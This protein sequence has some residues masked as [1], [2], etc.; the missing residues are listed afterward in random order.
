M[1]AACHSGRIL[2]RRVGRKTYVFQNSDLAEDTL[3]LR[4]VLALELVEN[5]VAV[6]AAFVWCCRPVAA[7]L[8]CQA[9]AV[10]VTARVAVASSWCAIAARTPIYIASVGVWVG[11]GARV[12]LEEG[13]A[14]VAL[15]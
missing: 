11:T 9:V 12:T 10:A 13:T 14:R 1:L 5:G 15:V 3:N 4:V 8:W 7:V 6:L 2:R